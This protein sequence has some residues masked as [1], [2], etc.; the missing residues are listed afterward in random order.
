MSCVQIA[1]TD[2]VD[3]LR[4]DALRVAQYPPRIRSARF[5]M[6][7]FH[8][9]AEDKIRFLMK[10]YG[11]RVT[12]G[13]VPGYT[14]DELERAQI[15]L[16]VAMIYQAYARASRQFSDADMVLVA[17]YDSKQCNVSAEVIDIPAAVP[18]GLRRC[19]MLAVDEEPGTCLPHDPKA[20]FGDA[21]WDFFQTR[22]IGCI[23]HEIRCA[24][25]WKPGSKITPGVF[26]V[27]MKTCKTCGG[28]SAFNGNSE[29]QACKANRNASELVAAEKRG[30]K[31]KKTKS[32]KAKF[33]IRATRKCLESLG[34]VF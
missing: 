28:P 6:C 25:N 19:W 17:R 34:F 31:K 7:A 10:R 23:R 4:E 33:E 27:W 14:S 20:F 1:L 2:V 30:M 18:L 13:A 11:I 24:N 29:C 15:T 16:N 32:C 8:E 9:K 22:G 5:M 12:V 3:A 21:L 26:A